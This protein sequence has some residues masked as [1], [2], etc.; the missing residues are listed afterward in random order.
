MLS[1]LGLTI[2]KHWQEHRPTSYRDLLLKGQLE[3]AIDDA[4]NRAFDVETAALYRGLNS[5]QARELGRQEW[6]S[7]RFHCAGGFGVPGSA[8]PQFRR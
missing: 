7:A 6:C 5:D 1:S 2:K 3:K 8:V 4:E